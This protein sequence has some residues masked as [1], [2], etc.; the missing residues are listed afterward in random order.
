MNFHDNYLDP[1][2]LITICWSNGILT[3]VPLEA[4]SDKND[5]SHNESIRSLTSLCTSFDES[6]FVRPSGE[7]SLNRRSVASPLQ[8]NSNGSIKSPQT[9]G[10]KNSVQPDKTKNPGISSP[11]RRSV[12]YSTRI[13]YD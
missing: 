9:N 8:V 11:F 13:Q 12:L 7:I 5:R 6:S 10:C 3:H 4:D 2:C 1:G